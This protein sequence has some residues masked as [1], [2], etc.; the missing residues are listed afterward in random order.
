MFCLG[1]ISWICWS[2]IWWPQVNNRLVGLHE[3]ICICCL[4]L[5]GISLGLAWVSSGCK[6]LRA[7]RGYTHQAIAAIATMV[8]SLVISCSARKGCFVC[9]CMVLFCVALKD[10]TVLHM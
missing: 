8:D 9:I 5:M 4:A 10:G 2:Y 6:S 7:H 1:A 3:L